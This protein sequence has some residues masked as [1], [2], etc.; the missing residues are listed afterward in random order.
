MKTKYVKRCVLTFLMIPFYLAF[1]N[2]VYAEQTEHP[3]VEKGREYLGVPY[4]NGG[5]SPDGFDSSGFTYYLFQETYHLTIPRTVNEQYELGESV[6]RGSIEP[7][8]LL[9]FRK[10]GSE[11]L[12][13]VAIFIGNDQLLHATVSGGISITP[14]EASAYWSGNFEGA[15]RMDVNV[16][17]EITEPTV[18]EALRHVGAPYGYGENGPDAFDPSGF[19]Q[20]VFSQVS[21]ADLPRTAAQQYRMGDPVER[22]ALEPGDVVFFGSNESNITHAAIYMGA[23]KMIHS[24]VSAGVQVTFL[25]GSSYWSGRYVGAKRMSEPEE[26]AYE[27]PLVLEALN[28][29][30]VP[31]ES[32]GTTPEG[33]DASGFVQYIF[34]RAVSITLPR[35]S[36]QQYMLGDEVQRNALQEGDLVFFSSNEAGTVN[37]VAIYMGNDQLIHPTVSGGVSVTFLEKSNY[38]ST[39]YV[40]AKRIAEEPPIDTENPIVSE[41]LKYEGVEYVFGGESPTEG[42]DCSGFVRYVFQQS[43]GT[44]LP[45]PADQQWMVGKEIEKDELEPGDVVFFSDTYKEGISH[46][47]IYIGGNRFIH[48]N[49][50]YEV[51]ITYLSSEYWQSKYSGARRYEQSEPIEHP[52]VQEAMKHVGEV[53]YKSGSMDPEEG[54]DTAG[55]I[56][57]V[58]DT[59]GGYDLPRYANGQ[60]ELGQLVARHELQPG[61]LVFFQLSTLNPAI[62]IGNDQVVHVTLSDGVRVTNIRTNGT[63][64]G[65]YYQARKYPVE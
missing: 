48:A 50:Q 59:V 38:W 35:T 41:A 21:A 30:G 45:R 20:Y 14:F 29:L 24:T 61:D 11:A 27:N 54:F 56:K 57:Y 28:Y 42:F 55:F 51:T 7:G 64:S 36:S 39:N 32:G 47:G 1:S 16:E 2:T 43:Q 5:A 65:Y 17:K 13:H 34:D 60:V 26:M 58:F 46:N 22:N 3:L 9:F 44:F 18:I 62:Y 15:R 40:G 53:P 6:E 33:F 8:D 19:V 52:I 63:W 25:E 37:H 23:D 10:S 31:F 49:R 4:A 12:T